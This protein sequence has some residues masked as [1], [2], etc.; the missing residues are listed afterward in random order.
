M[1]HGIKMYTVAFKLKY[2]I[3]LYQVVFTFYINIHSVSQIDVYTLW[4]VIS[5]QQNE[6][7]IQFLLCMIL[8]A[9]VKH[10]NTFIIFHVFKL[11]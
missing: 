3:L 8:K 5:Q 1:K 4:N 10:R 9:L 2:L 7:E 6:K 11:T